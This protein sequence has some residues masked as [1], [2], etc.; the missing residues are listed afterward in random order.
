MQCRAAAEKI[1]AKICGAGKSVQR[2]VYPGLFTKPSF[3]DE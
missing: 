1:S 2:E 3:V